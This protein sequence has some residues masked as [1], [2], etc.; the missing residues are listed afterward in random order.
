MSQE[1]Y[2]LMVNVV[3]ETSKREVVQVDSPTIDDKYLLKLNGIKTL[4]H[5]SGSE[6]PVRVVVAKDKVNMTVQSP[7][8]QAP[9]PLLNASKTKVAE[10]IYMVIRS[11]YGVPVLHQFLIHLLNCRKWTAAVLDDIRV[12]KVS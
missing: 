3:G 1:L 11:D 12:E 2:D 7:R 9:V 5:R 4:N 6:Y 8:L 10:M